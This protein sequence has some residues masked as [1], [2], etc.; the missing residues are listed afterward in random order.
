MPEYRFFLVIHRYL[1]I[2]FYDKMYAELNITLIIICL[3]TA[4]EYQQSK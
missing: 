2:D 3:H 1:D 4:K